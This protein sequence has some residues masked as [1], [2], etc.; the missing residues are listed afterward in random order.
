[1]A[2]GPRQAPDPAVLLVS[3]I[4]EVTARRGTPTPS[5]RAP[6]VDYASLPKLTLP[7]LKTIPLNGLAMTPPMGWNSWNKFHTKVDDVTVRGI[8]DA[9][10]HKRD[11]RCRI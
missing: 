5:Y 9:I 7:A 2:E 8:A 10:A 6:S 11:E 3:Q 1:M 4:G